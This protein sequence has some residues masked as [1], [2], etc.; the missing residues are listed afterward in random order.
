[1]HSTLKRTLSRKSLRWPRGPA[2]TSLTLTHIVIRGERAN[3]VGKGAARIA[4]PAS[5]PVQNAS[6]SLLYPE[7]DAYTD[8][9]IVAPFFVQCE[10]VRISERNVVE[11]EKPHSEVSA[12]LDVNASADSQR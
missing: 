8:A 7:C 11:L 3:C 5:M 9:E 10:R 1:M 12:D 4:A 6:L 2:W